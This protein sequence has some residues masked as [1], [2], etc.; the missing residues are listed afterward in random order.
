MPRQQ[1][2]SLIS[3]LVPPRSF[4]DVEVTT[5]LERSA[6][7]QHGSPRRATKE[8]QAL[9]TRAATSGIM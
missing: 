3:S 5:R 9:L 8:R 2:L 4:F 7:D 1:R 6:N